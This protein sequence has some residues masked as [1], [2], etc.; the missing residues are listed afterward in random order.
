MEVDHINH[1]KLDNRKSNLR[2]CTHQQN[3]MNVSD[4]VKGIHYDKSRNKW[5]AH[6]KGKNLGRFNTKEEAIEARKQ[7]EMDYF[8]EYRNKENDE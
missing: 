3:C 8:G 4:N 1:N 7:A 2:I 5:M 6:I